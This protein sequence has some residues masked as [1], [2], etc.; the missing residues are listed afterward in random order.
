[1]GIRNG[2]NIASDNSALVANA[3][4]DLLRRT[5]K[6]EAN[7]PKAWSIS[8]KGGVLSKIREY[9]K[10]TVEQEVLSSQRS[11]MGQA[12]EIDDFIRIMKLRWS[13]D[14]NELEER[15]LLLEEKGRGK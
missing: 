14:I 3:V 6:L 4:D 10:K 1:M 5:K 12:R 13:Q 7:T 8:G 11:A 9:I 15:I 2:Y